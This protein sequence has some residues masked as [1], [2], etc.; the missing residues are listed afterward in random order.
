MRSKI[1]EPEVQVRDPVISLPRTIR[2]SLLI[3]ESGR[4]VKM[5]ARPC[6]GREVRRPQ[7]WFDEECWKRIPFGPSR[8]KYALAK[9]VSAEPEDGGEARRCTGH[10]PVKTTEDGGPTIR[11]PAAV[12]RCTLQ[13]SR[14]YMREIA[15]GHV[16]SRWTPRS[17][18]MHRRALAPTRSACVLVL[19][20]AIVADARIRG[21]DF[22]S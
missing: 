10:P 7:G 21:N 2:Q 22:T 15:A 19:S 17:A 5:P 13:R 8:L 4:S 3:H 14:D 16:E 1:S 18:K 12:D 20:S 11:L 9:L 6:G